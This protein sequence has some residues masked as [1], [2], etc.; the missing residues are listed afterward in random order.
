MMGCERRFWWMGIKWGNHCFWDWDFALSAMEQLG[1]TFLSPANISW[2]VGFPS[3]KGA[4]VHQRGKWIVVRHILSWEWWLIC[5]IHELEIKLVRKFQLFF[6]F[7]FSPFPFSF[8]LFPFPFFSFSLFPFPILHTL[9][10]HGAGTSKFPFSLAGVWW[11]LSSFLL[12]SFG[13]LRC[14]RCGKTNA[15]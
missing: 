14:I 5:L 1:N 3:S 9:L 2:W 6:P 15:I 4:E 7:P 11:F 12:S 8:F 10:C 13:T